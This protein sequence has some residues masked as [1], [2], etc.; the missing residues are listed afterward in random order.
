MTSCR[1]ALKRSKGASTEVGSQGISSMRRSHHVV[2]LR[3]QTQ[4]GLSAWMAM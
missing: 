4:A 3:C 2:S 1:Q